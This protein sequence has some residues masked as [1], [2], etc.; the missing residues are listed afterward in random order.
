MNHLSHH[1]AALRAAPDA[2][3]EFF[4]GNLLP[5]LIATGG[6]GRI[7]AVEPAGDDLTRGVRL[8]L[9]SDRGFH[10]AEEFK[11]A[12]AAAS[13]ALRAEPFE[14]PPV[15]LFFVAHV[16]VELALDAAVLRARPDAA[17][18][19]YRRL[20]GVDPEAVAERAARWLRPE[21]VA[22][23]LALANT[24]RRFVAARYL[25][26]YARPDGLAEGIYRIGRRVGLEN[27]ASDTDLR[28]LAAVFDGFAGRADRLYRELFVDGPFAR[29]EAW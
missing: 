25:Y 6:D 5:D 1:E 15:R 17:D 22:H 21:A 26:D 16:F 28:A 27:F 19:L 11:T 13:A 18:D 23:G 10:G 14:T 2:G 24:V 3:P 8:H 7:R 29:P 12:T 9:W 4:L 20:A